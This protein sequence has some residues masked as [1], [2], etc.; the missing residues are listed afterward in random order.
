MKRNIIGV[1][2]AT[3]VMALV[4]AFIFFAHVG[5]FRVLGIHYDSTGVLINFLLVG[6]LLEVVLLIV[7][8]IIIRM[9]SKYGEISVSARV[10]A[11]V[12]L[13]VDFV[14]IHYIDEMMKGITIETWTEL[15]LAAIF[16]LL[17][18]VFEEED[19]NRK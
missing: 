1:L 2:A 13:I 14:S 4:C 10:R 18:K 19:V 6:M 7:G 3:S 8:T 5:L 15:A 16:L 12:T 11:S 9:L 17:N